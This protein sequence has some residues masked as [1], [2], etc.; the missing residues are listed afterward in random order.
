MGPLSIALALALL[1]LM[2]RKLGKVTHASSY[3]VGFFI[4]AL[5][6]CASVVVRFFELFGGGGQQ[7][8]AM[9]LYDLLLAGGVT[10]GVI[11]GWHYWSWLLAERD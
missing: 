8:D 1:G 6:V 5:L 4:A 11:C 3:Y 2:S 9:L 10:L 7:Q